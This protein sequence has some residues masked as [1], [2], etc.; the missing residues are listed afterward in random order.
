MSAT[1]CSPKLTEKPPDLF[2]IPNFTMDTTNTTSA[3]PPAK[4]EYCVFADCIVRCYQDVSAASAEEAYR[5]AEDNPEGWEFCSDA[6]D[7]DYRLSNEVMDRESEEFIAVGSSAVTHCKTCGSDI[8]E[9]ANDCHFRE[10]ECG[11]CEHKRYRSQPAL[12]EHL[13][14]LIETAASASGNR[15]NG[16]A[17]ADALDALDRVAERAKAALAP[18]GEAT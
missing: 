12:L 14:T 15:E 10:G 13:L 18:Y 7:N 5:L 17:L 9:T 3:T 16:N 6:G 11:T 1:K 4:K 8:V 2:P